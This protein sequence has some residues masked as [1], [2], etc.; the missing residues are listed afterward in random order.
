MFCINVIKQT[1]CMFIK[2]LQL[3]EKN[4][5]KNYR[6]PLYTSLPGSW[7]FFFFSLHSFSDIVF[8]FLQHA[9]RVP[10]SQPRGLVCVC[11][12]L[13]TAAPQLRL[14]PSVCAAT[15]ITAGTLISR[16]NPAQVSIFYIQTYFYTCRINTF[17]R[18]ICVD[19]IHV[20]WNMY[21][22]SILNVLAMHINHYSSIASLYSVEYTL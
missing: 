11:S 20:G 4:S 10:S 7:F 17:N 3:E 5:N 12:V 1:C 6:L 19:I 8:L 13:L 21:L 18:H 16:M 15:A 2:E 22:T 14:L 9:R